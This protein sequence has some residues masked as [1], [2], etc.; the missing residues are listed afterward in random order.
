M[1]EWYV[2]VCVRACVYVYLCV[3]ACMC[4]YVCGWVVEGMGVCAIANVTENVGG[5]MGGD[6]QALRWCKGM[7]VCECECE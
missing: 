1:N 7:C 3:R 4:V 6:R 2:S 5:W